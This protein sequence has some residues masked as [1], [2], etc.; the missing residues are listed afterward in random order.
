MMRL[1][2]FVAL[3]VLLLA[4]TADAQCAWVLWYETTTSSFSYRT[5]DANVPGGGTGTHKQE[6][7]SWDILSSSPT[8][9]GCES[10]KEWKI[11]D[12]L[13]RWRKEKAE[14][15]FGQH[16]ITH[17]SGSNI[18]SKDS[19]HVNEYTS[20]Y[21]NSVRYLCLPDT[22]DPRAPKGARP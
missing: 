22:V 3:A 13:K 15:K 4:A 21:S 5:A 17:E 9:A 7:H 6:T 20:T 16:T 1:L 2:I 14:A 10:Q 18:I 11:G 12:V 19:K 8:N